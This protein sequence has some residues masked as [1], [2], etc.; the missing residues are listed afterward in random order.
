[1][2]K[3]RP[4]ETVGIAALDLNLLKVL[5]ALLREGSTVRAAARVGLSQP[6]VSAALARLRQ[7]LGD[8][9]FVRR[10]RGLEATDFAREI[11]PDVHRL[12]EDIEAVLRGKSRFDPATEE[13]AFRISGN[14][15]FAP[16]LLPRL[17]ARLAA[18]A[19]GIVVQLIDLPY[20]VVTDALAPGR[21]DLV[22][23]RDIEPAEWL[24]RR[25]LIDVPLCVCARVGHPAVAAAGLRRG[26]PMPLDLYCGLRHVIYSID[27]SRAGIEEPLLA[28]LG[29]TRSV[30]QTVPDFSS[31]FSV[32]ARSDLIAL[33]PLHLAHSFDDGRIH[34][35]ATPFP[36]AP[37]RVQM[38]WA[39]RS[40]DFPAH[41]WLRSLVADIMARLPSG[42]P[43]PASTP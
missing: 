26:R 28:E 1:M 34:V 6:A 16:T 29:C 2:G 9:L 39:R 14:D 24:V 43:P 3:G 40:H 23:D 10:G 20:P 15:F 41:R 32:V 42:F 30:A 17:E 19:P 36:I 38:A 25:D 11:E 8:P 21:A 27:G 5:D 4:G 31:A 35:Y 22:L 7:S 33:L 37:V 12:I 13:R 18:E